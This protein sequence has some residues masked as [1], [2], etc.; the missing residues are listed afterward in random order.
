[1]K[2]SVLAMS[3][4]FHIRAKLSW[5]AADAFCAVKKRKQQQLTMAT[6]I[7]SCCPSAARLKI[8]YRSS[9]VLLTAV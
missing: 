5:S 8:K 9:D 6:L 4:L 7:G 2:I 3:T 1:M